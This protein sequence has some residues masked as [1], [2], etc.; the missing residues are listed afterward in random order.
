MSCVCSSVIIKQTDV[1]RLEQRAFYSL[2][3][4]FKLCRFYL[5]MNVR[6]KTLSVLLLQLKTCK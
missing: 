1:R 6:F 5:A 4:S 2:H 3:A